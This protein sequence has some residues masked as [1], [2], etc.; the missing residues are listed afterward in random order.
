MI[1]IDLIILLPLGLIGEMNEGLEA[2]ELLWFLKLYRIKSTFDFIDV[3][4][5]NPMIRK[6]HQ[7]RLDR[8]MND[9]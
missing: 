6:Y 9:H 3:K 5:Y 1:I 7:N 4:V 8:I 2:F